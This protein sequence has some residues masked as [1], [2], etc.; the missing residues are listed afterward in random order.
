VKKIIKRAIW[1]FY[2]PFKYKI[3]F[4]RAFKAYNKMAQTNKALKEN[5]YPCLYDATALTDIEPVYFLQDSWA[6]ERIYSVRPINHIDIG[7]GHKFVSLLSKTTNLTMVD[8]RPLAISINSIKFIEGNILQLPFESESIHSLSSLCVIEHIGLGRYGDQ[9][10]PE[11]SEKAFKEIDRVLSIGANLYFSVPVE[12]LNTVYF[13]AHRSF[14]EDYLFKKLLT[15]YEILD[16]KY[17]Y[18]IRLESAINASKFGIGCYHIRKN[19]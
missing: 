10:D 17:I 19:K 14:N 2:K 8:I 6:F 7:S 3:K 16:K 11:G 1:F 12:Q 15:N 9:L 13:N 18:D 5:L 4:R